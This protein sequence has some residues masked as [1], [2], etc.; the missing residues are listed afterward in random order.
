MSAARSPEVLIQLRGSRV[1]PGEDARRQ[2]V[3]RQLRWWE[4]EVVKK[5][6]MSEVK[7]GRV[8][9]DPAVSLKQRGRDEG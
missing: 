7:E 5:M 6:T 9:P 4:R 8:V 2:E 1:A 3:R